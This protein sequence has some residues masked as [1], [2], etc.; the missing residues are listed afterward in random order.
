VFHEAE[1]NFEVILLLMFMVAGIYFMKELLLFVFT[2]ILLKIRSKILL[3]LLFSFVAAFL[4][5]FLD[6]LTVTAVLISV[7]WASTAVY[8]KVASGKGV[9]HDDHD[10]GD[11]D[12]FRT[13]TARTSRSFAPSCAPC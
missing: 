8:H 11:D 13:R 4:S 5:A 1:A 12:R 3:S 6:A 9:H 7:A 10:H 2:R